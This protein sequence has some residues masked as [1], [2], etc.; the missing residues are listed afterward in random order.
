MILTLTKKQFLF[1]FLVLSPFFL[2]STYAQEKLMKTGIRDLQMIVDS[3]EFP[4]GSV[5][6]YIANIKKVSQINVVIDIDT[7]QVQLPPVSLKNISISNAL[8]WITLTA[9]AKER[10]LTVRFL[11]NRPGTNGG[12]V[13]VISISRRLAERNA[14]S[15][16]VPSTVQTTSTKHMKVFSLKQAFQ[17]LSNSSKLENRHEIT[18]KAIDLALGLLESNPSDKP[19]VKYDVDS[20]LLMVRGTDK[21]IDTVT[22]LLAQLTNQRRLHPTRV[23]L[24]IKAELKRMEEKINKLEFE[25]VDIQRSM[26][27]R[28]K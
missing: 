9:E 3:V 8:N 17:N 15:P 13:T 2:V 14:L 26:N 10:A 20:G 22:N 12:E 23:L 24:P 6:D 19:V 4:G 1:L 18:L 5:A 21:Q 25:I 28:S 16:A 7:G 11:R 27:T